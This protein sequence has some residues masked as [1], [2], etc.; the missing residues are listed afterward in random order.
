MK[1]EKGSEE[2]F[3]IVRRRQNFVYWCAWR[4]WL[5]KEAL[6][7]F[8]P[9]VMTVFGEW[10][11]RTHEAARIVAR[12]IN[13]LRGAEKIPITPMNETPEPWAMYAFNQILDLERRHNEDMSWLPEAEIR[14]RAH[15]TATEIELDNWMHNEIQKMPPVRPGESL[16]AWRSRTGYHASE[17]GG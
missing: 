8:F 14:T 16:H 7:T 13:G 10:P 6:R 1:P 4:E 9:D 11:P 3:W 15:R 2:G 12:Q 17:V 5:A